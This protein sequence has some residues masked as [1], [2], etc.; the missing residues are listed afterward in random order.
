MVKSS[1]PAVMF[2]GLRASLSGFNLQTGKVLWTQSDQAGLSLLEVNPLP[3]AD[4]QHIVI[5][6][7]GVPRLLDVSSGTTAAVAAG[8]VLWC[9]T[10]PE[11]K[12]AGIPSYEGTNTMTGSNQYFGCTASGRAVAGHPANQPSVVGVKAG[13]KFFW[14]TPRG[15]AAAPA[16]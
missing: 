8:S 2:G 10:S 6:Q 13:S 12:V 16:S 1:N 15:L 14:L 4:A 7:R 5:R 9:S 3:I 11:I